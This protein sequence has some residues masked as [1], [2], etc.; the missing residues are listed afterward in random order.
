MRRAIPVIISTAG[1]LALLSN[2][3]TAPR[4]ASVATAPEASSSTTVTTKPS[5]GSGP[6]STTPTTVAGD[7]RTIDGP[8]VPTDYGNVQV[9]VTLQGTKIVDV[10][11]IQLPFDRS[12]SQR[13]SD[14]AAPILHNEVLKAQS[15]NIDLV[16][17]ASYTSDAYAQSLQGALDHAGR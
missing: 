1:G 17:G 10:Q 15:A 7:K 3:H 6:T 12:R 11:G 4:A 8:V 14:Y 13:L 5:R 2:F 16:S 9:R